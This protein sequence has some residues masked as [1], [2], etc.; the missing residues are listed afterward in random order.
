MSSVAPSPLH[1]QL[2]R[3]SRR[4][5]IQKL[6]DALAWSWAGALLVA[7]VWFLVQ[8]YALGQ[9]SEWL[10]WTVAG[11]LLGISTVAAVVVAILQA[12]NQ[13]TAALELDGR[14]GLRERVTT[15]MTLD[16]YSRD[17]S[18]AAALLEDVNHRVAGLDVSDRFPVRMRWNAVLLPAG[19]LLLAVIAF[20][21]N[22]TFTI[23]ITPPEE[24]GKKV[25]ENKQDI[26][27]AIKELRDKRDQKKSEKADT[28]KI[29]PTDDELKNLLNKPHD[30]KDDVRDRVK[31]INKLEAK[32]E[33]KKDEIAQKA[34]AMRDQLK[35]INKNN[36]GE[37]K[38]GPAKK[39]QEA[40]DKGDFNKAQEEVEKL[41]K[42][43][44]EGKLDEKEKEQLKEQLKAMK[45][46]ME[47]AANPDKQEEKLKELKRE[48]KID[49]EQFNKGMENVKKNRE[50]LTDEDRKNLEDVAEALK[51]AEKAMREGDG[52]KADEALKRAG[53]AMKKSD[54]L[55]QMNDAQ[56]QLDQLA[57]LKGRMMRGMNG[58][59]VPGAGNRPEGD[60]HETNSFRTKIKGDFDPKGQKELTGLA[61]GPAFKKKSEKEIAGDIKQA[62]QEAPEAIERQRIPRAA[63]DMAKGYFENIRKGSEDK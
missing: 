60:P 18:A 50:G 44:E 62:S 7:A 47:Q 53:Q 5:F 43:M 15:S 33:Q 42:K 6:V 19:G 48:G 3:V 35:Q 10:R 61:N 25:V 56:D 8:P 59:P 34:Q 13:L 2:G 58:N 46:K 57:D 12:P 30:T 63:S 23:A 54:D 17:T 52:A 11:G 37:M 39:L 14:F 4:L 55:D 40:M 1:R 22:P 24:E 51:D 9:Q 29:E 28:D 21:Y 38:D 32:A 26:D 36:G 20:F 45:D 49:E 31:D 16:R 41:R 27:K